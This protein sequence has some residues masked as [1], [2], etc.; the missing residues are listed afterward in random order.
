MDKKLIEK[1]QFGIDDGLNSTLDIIKD[2]Y[3]NF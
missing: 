1:I 2:T 3:K